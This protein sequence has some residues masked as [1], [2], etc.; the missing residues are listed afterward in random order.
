[1]TP[2][3]SPDT[4]RVYAD[5]TPGALDVR[6][7]LWRWLPRLG[8]TASLAL[9]HLATVAEF[10]SPSLPGSSTVDIPEMATAL[11]V[12]PY[13]LRHAID[14]LV[15]FRCAAWLSPEALAIRMQLPE[16]ARRPE[17]AEAT[18]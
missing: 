15:R 8:P 17:P 14:R 11:G 6:Q 9:Q 4:I 10:T 7:A 2:L 16:R 3:S 12:K 13:V 18:S 1:M 5:W